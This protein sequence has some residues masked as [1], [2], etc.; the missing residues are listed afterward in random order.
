MKT[1]I[2]PILL[3]FL[4][5]IATATSN[6]QDDKKVDRVEKMINESK[7]HVS[8]ANAVVQVADQQQK[9]KMNEL[10]KT[11]CKLEKEKQM[12]K[13]TLELTKNELVVIKEV[14]YVNST[15]STKY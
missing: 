9:E 11:V 1:I 3:L 8:K 10:R 6:K 2:T 15:D 14:V 5:I 13:S 4:L 7:E 12:L